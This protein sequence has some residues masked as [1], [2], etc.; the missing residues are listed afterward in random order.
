LESDG[1][2]L[3]SGKFNLALGSFLSGF[4]ESTTIQVGQ[5]REHTINDQGHLTANVHRLF[6]VTRQ[7][8]GAAPVDLD[9]EATY[10]QQFLGLIYTLREHVSAGASKGEG[11]AIE[12]ARHEH[13]G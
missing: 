5:L 11:L 2:F 10:R 6:P 3:E 9:F 1:C 13:A 7:G 4:V 12:G 8:V